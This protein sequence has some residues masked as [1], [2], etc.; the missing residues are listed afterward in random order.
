MD[1]VNDV[2]S[3]YTQDVIVAFQRPGVVFKL[4]TSEIIFTQPVLL[5]HGPHPSVQHHDPLLQDGFDLGLQ[6]FLH[7]CFKDSKNLTLKNER[8]KRCVWRGSLE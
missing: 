4:L 3:S 1:L 2:R 7:A 6:G 5:D 8:G